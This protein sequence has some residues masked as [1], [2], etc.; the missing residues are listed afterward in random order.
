MLLART[1]VASCAVFAAMI[2]TATAAKPT[3]IEFS[4]DVPSRVPTVEEINA[5]DYSVGLRLKNTSQEDIVIWPY[6]TVEVLDSQGNEVK[7]SMLIGRNGIRFTPSLI[8][9]IDFVKLIPG[10]THDINI[11]FSQYVS[12]PAFIT[13][14]SF[15][16]SGE[17]TV[18][19]RYDYNIA[20]EKKR[21]GRRCKDLERVDAPWNHAVEVS[22]TLKATLKVR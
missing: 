19:M 10:Q 2:S 13:G 20:A 14:W 22:S 7:R 1:S 15:P 4:V 8:E 11:D 21:L 18:V 17:Y 6:L 12:D 16:K 3:P 9:G 5:G